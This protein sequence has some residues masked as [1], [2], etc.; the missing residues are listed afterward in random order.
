MILKGFSNSST[1]KTVAKKKTTKMYYLFHNT[2]EYL[3]R[4]YAEELKTPEYASVREK[5]LQLYEGVSVS[6]NYYLVKG[7]L[8]CRKNGQLVKRIMLER[9]TDEVHQEVIDKLLEEENHT[10]KKK[11]GGKTKKVNVMKDF[12]KISRESAI[13]IYVFNLPGSLLAKN[14]LYADLVHIKEFES[15]VEDGFIVNIAGLRMGEDGLY[16][17]K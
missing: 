13:R 7:E 12:T 6:Q 4:N 2:I 9:D 11:Y 10:K 16:H 8:R 17:F 1:N 15:T 3:D 14:T 5:L